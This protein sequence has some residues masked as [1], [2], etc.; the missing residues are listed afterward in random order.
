MKPTIRGSSLVEIRG[1]FRREIWAKRPNVSLGGLGGAFRAAVAAATRII[2]VEFEREKEMAP[3]GAKGY[4]P[5][6]TVASLD[7]AMEIKLANEKH[8][9][10]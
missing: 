4:V 6:F 9:A 10:R 3:V 2:G 5:D 8:S 1:R 7:L